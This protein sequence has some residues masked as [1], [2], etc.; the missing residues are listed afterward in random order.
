MGIG[1]LLGVSKFLVWVLFLA[2]MKWKLSNILLLNVSGIT[3]EKPM[4]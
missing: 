2:S 3:N 4:I 1:A